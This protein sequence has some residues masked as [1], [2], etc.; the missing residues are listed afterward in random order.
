MQEHGLPAAFEGA[1]LNDACAR[2]AVTCA[3]RVPVVFTYALHGRRKG[4][5]VGTFVITRNQ[6]PADVVDAF[7]RSAPVAAAL[8]KLKHGLEGGRSCRAVLID[9]A[10]AFFDRLP[11]LRSCA[12]RY[13]LLYRK[14]VADPATG[15]QKEVYIWGNETDGTPLDE[16]ADT[17]HA[18]VQQH[19]LNPGYFQAIL[20]DACSKPAVRCTR[21]S[22]QPEAR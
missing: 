7:C 4:G 14:N 12:R 1:L 8:G 11:E 2:P 19:G 10:C 3:R 21:A 6:E 15:F 13:S 18:F 9:V 17:V 22:V 5:A 20:R 16:P